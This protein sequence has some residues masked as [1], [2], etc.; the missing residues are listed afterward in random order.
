M[1][2]KVTDNLETVANE[3]IDTCLY[4]DSRDNMSIIIIVFTNAS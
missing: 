1:R 4:E 3:V 2:M